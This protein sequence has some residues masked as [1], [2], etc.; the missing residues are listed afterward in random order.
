MTRTM[1]LLTAAALLATPLA[2]QSF[3][4]E[5]RVIV[6]PTST[7][8]TVPDGAG[9]GDRGIWCAA[10]DYASRVL[11]ARG[12]QRVYVAEDRTSRQPAAFTLDS[13]GLTP[14][15]VF[16]VGGSARRAGSS[17]TVDHAMLFCADA[18]IINR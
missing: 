2:A 15:R 16:I 3:R 10:A 8:F 17:L 6:T 7:G 12:T 5:N 11:G 14:R 4:A 9:H 13:A 18:R 1:A